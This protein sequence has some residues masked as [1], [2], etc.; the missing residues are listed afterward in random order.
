MQAGDVRRMLVECSEYCEAFV[1]YLNINWRYEYNGS[2][3]YRFD[4]TLVFVFA[5]EDDAINFKLKYG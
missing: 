2:D 1:G 4:R 3:P 5:N